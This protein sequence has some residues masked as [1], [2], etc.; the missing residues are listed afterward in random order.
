MAAFYRISEQLLNCFITTANLSEICMH[1]MLWRRTNAPWTKESCL[2]NYEKYSKN[3]IFPK[4]FLLNR[5]EKV[6]FPLKSWGP[7]KNV[8][9]R[10]GSY[11][12]LGLSIY[13]IKWNLNIAGLSL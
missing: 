7:L 10:S 4:E 12:G 8:K 1:M 5:G 3:I 6:S 9:P 11:S 13:V 2:K